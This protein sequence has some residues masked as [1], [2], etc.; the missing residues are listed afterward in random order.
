MTVGDGA[1]GED[2]ILGFCDKILLIFDWESGL[3]FNCLLI[4]QF[5]LLFLMKRAEMEK[6]STL[7]SVLIVFYFRASRT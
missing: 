3:H 7:R 4:S 5:L 1:E 6:H 2:F